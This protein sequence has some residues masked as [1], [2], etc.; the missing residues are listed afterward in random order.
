MNITESILQD[1][2]C[3]PQLNNDLLHFAAIWLLVDCL[4]KIFLKIKTFLKSSG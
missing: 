3:D 4:R 2:N 1:K